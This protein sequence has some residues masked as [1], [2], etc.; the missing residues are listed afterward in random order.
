MLKKNVSLLLAIILIVFFFNCAHLKNART[1]YEAR[2]Y[3]QVIALCR[4]AIDSDSTSVEAYLLMGRSYRALDSLDQALMAIKSAYQL[5]PE[6]PETIAELTQTYL[7]L[8]D[9]ALSGDRKRQALEYFNTAESLNPNQPTALLSL[10]DLHFGQGDLDIA[11]SKY[12]KL[13]SIAPDSSVS[14]RL[15]EIESRTQTASS[16]YDKGLTALKRNRLKTAKSMFAKAVKLKADF[17]DAR[18]HLLIAEGRLQYKKA[19]KKSYWDAIDAFG[20]AAALKSDAAE[21]HFR[22]ALAYEKKDPDEFV[23]AIDEYETAL[24]LEPDGPFSGASRKKVKE[25]KARKEKMDKFW[26]RKK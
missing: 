10:A 6:S 18:Y 19:T 16:F 7:S 4:E 13:A 20:R 2:D 25:L 9:H 17:N 5:Q 23:N 3:R 11:R 12:E 15:A 14:A 22:L 21:P 8:G 1:A 24:R 26:G